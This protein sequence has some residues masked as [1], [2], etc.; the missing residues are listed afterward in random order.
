M[1][2]SGPVRVAIDARLVP[3]QGTGVEQVT[4]GL[5]RAL[6]L[7]DDA[8]D[9][10]VIVTSPKAPDWVAEYLGPNQRIVVGPDVFRWAGFKRKLGP[11]RPL[12]A[13]FFQLSRRATSLMRPAAKRSGGGGS[14]EVRSSPFHEGLGVDVVHFPAANF[15]STR[16]PMV[17]NP[18]D[19]QHLHFPQFFKS[20]YIR[21]REERFQSG[22][23]QAQ[24]VAL[25]SE[26]AKADF[27]EHY[28][29]DPAKIQVIPWAAPIQAQRDLDDAKL[30]EV[31]SEYGLPEMFVLFPAA[32]WKHKNHIALLR[33][34]ASLRDEAD[35]RVHLV[36][37]GSKYDHWPEIEREIE[38]LKLH[39]QVKFLGMVPIDHLRAL[40]RLAQFLIFPSL[41]EPASAPVMEAWSEGIPVACSSAAGL[42]EQVGDGAYLFDP[43]SVSEIAE[44]LR[45]MSLDSTLRDDI[46]QRGIVRSQK[47]S[48]EKTARAY[49]AVYRRLAGRPLDSEESKLL[50]E[51]WTTAPPSDS[52]FG[53]RSDSPG[54]KPT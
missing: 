41:H 27:I 47:F 9:E 2:I 40:Y 39:D 53:S 44:A 21:E 45:V 18:H 10:Y 1:T 22:C 46:R 50:S 6:G 34:I 49:R 32:T 17:F 36:C 35:L 42:M 48:W 43:T 13:Y 16:I 8:D 52:R 3:G 25:G 5:I 4:V 19:L 14:A 24:V 30:P 12:G 26:W 23:D 37:T 31:V 54:G 20:E 29:L 11:L 28:G 38:L 7:L 33:A 15:V 51:N